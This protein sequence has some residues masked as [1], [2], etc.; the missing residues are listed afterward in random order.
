MKYLLSFSL[1][2]LS[3]GA[4]AQFEDFGAISA[5]EADLK[6]CSFDPDASAVVLLDEGFSD[7]TDERGLMTYYHESIKILKEEG[8]KYADV[9]FN[10]YH[11]DDFETV[12]NIEAVTINTDENGRRRTIPIENK[13]IYSKRISKYRT[14]ISFAFPEVKPGTIIEYKYRINAKSYGGLRDWY[15][16]SGIP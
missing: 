10:Y 11:D 13:S 7:F 1:T 2:L 6:S 12:D 15:F 8:V 5:A 16:Q 9:K 4:F 14:E 3:A